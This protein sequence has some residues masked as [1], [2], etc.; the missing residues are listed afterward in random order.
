MTLDPE[1]IKARIA[2]MQSADLLL[3]AENAATGM[4]RYLDDFRRNPDEAYL[5]EIK[6]AAISMDFVVDEMAARLQRN[7]EQLARQEQDS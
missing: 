5:G 3:W 7:R 2:R 6:L 4:Q 1:K